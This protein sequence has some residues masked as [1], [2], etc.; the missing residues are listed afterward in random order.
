MQ[1]GDGAVSSDRS[2]QR[3]QELVGLSYDEQVASLR[4]SPDT[5]TAKVQFNLT[6]NSDA[7]EGETMVEAVVDGPVGRLFNRV[8]GVEESR[9]DTACLTFVQAQ[10]E[11]YLD[12]ELQMSENE[13]FRGL[14][15]T[16]IAEAL[17]SNLDTNGDGLVGWEEFKFFENEILDQ[18]A[19]GLEEGA[20]GDEVEAAASNRFDDLSGTQ[21]ELGYKTLNSRADEAIPPDMEHRGLLAQ[22][23]ARITIDALDRDERNKPVAERSL[24]PEEWAGGARE[25]HDNRTTMS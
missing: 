15:L 3:R 14:K 7:P 19:P 20:T 9:T 13:W 23:A 22:L 10:L 16:G 25:I 8:C 5:S 17:M 12:T 21:G 2:L 4:P 11:A 1:Q 18:V 6:T 24:S